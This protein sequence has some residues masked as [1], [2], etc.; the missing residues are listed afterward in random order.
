MALLGPKNSAYFPF[1]QG[2]IAFKLEF[3]PLELV[4]GF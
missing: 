4:R 1:S 3:M 2:L